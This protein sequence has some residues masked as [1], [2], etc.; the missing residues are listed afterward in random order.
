MEIR[1]YRLLRLSVPLRDEQYH[2]VGLDCR[3]DGRE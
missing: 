3:F 2:L 1:G